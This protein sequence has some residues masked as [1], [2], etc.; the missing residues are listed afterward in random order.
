MKV[1]KKIITYV[2]HL[3]TRSTLQYHTE[4]I[5]ILT[6]LKNLIHIYNATICNDV[7]TS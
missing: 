6:L 3:R 4:N 5:K 1:V 7:S 2:K